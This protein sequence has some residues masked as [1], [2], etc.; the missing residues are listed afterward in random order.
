MPGDSPKPHK[1]NARKKEVDGI[2]FD[3]TREAKRYLELKVMQ[4]AGIISHL[5][6]QPRFLIQE[7]FKDASGKRHRRME[8]VG[9]F[10]YT[11]VGDQSY[12][13][14]TVEDCKGFQTQAFRLKWKLV[15]QKFPF[16][17]FKMVK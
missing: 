10:Q 11:N 1:Y 17:Y 6:L 5:E 7:S 15:N 4:Q 12:M 3:S 9:D 13:S 16:I 8:Y 14:E 2:L